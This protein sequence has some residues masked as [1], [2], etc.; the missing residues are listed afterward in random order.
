MPRC[1]QGE[2]LD[3]RKIESR[4]STRTVVVDAVESIGSREEDDDGKRK[5]PDLEK[6]E[7]SPST[8][9]STTHT[10]ITVL[11][12]ASDDDDDDDD[13]SAN[14][15]SENNSSNSSNNN[16]NNNNDNRAK[17]RM[18]P[19]FSV[20]LHPKRRVDADADISGEDD[21]RIES[22]IRSDGSFWLRGLFNQSDGPSGEAEAAVPCDSDIQG[23]VDCCSICLE[24]YRVGDTLARLKRTRTTAMDP[25]EDIG[26]RKTKSCCNHWFHEDCII[27]WLQDHDDCPLCRVEMVHN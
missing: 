14:S 21:D 15:T 1:S 16:D 26:E 22:S 11:S 7:A 8:S 23:E 24:P 5:P 4:P 19:F 3:V 10:R 13:D 20:L 17:D 6:G 18:R 27:E 25:S 9:N 12:S 2:C